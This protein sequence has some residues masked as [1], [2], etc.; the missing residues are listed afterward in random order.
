MR[1]EAGIAGNCAVKVG[2]DSFTIYRRSAR[3]A[4]A[5]ARWSLGPTPLPLPSAEANNLTVLGARP[6]E[7]V[8]DLLIALDEGEGR[9]PVT[10]LE[11]WR[12]S[13][14]RVLHRFQVLELDPTH[15]VRDYRQWVKVTSHGFSLRSV[16]RR[17][18]IRAA[19]DEGSY[20]GHQFDFFEFDV[21]VSYKSEDEE[22]AS[23]LVQALQDRGLAVWFGKTCIRAGDYDRQIKEGLSRSGAFVV[24]WNDHS[25]VPKESIANG[26]DWSQADEIDF[27]RSK[28]SH[29][30]FH[31]KVN[32]ESAVP[33][34]DTRHRFQVT[35]IQETPVEEFADLVLEG[36]Y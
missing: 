4:K 17:V 3:N 5:T 26:R 30:I 20:R 24:L 10:R 1:G 23:R 25:E 14:L 27:I 29:P 22:V 35:D 15:R 9:S 8:I 18:L 28:E 34:Q 2:A 16:R 7:W 33:D 19:C 31:Y 32:R 12:T 11:V 6:H 36:L 21:F 13:P